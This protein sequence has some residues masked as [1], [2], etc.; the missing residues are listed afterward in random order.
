MIWAFDVMPREGMEWGRLGR[1]GLEEYG[2]C[3]CHQNEPSL[4][5]H[6][7]IFP[8]RDHRMSLKSV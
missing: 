6:N 2:H 5:V 3:T 7:I 1:D 8:R 4:K